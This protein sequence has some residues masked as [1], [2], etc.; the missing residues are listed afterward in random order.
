MVDFPIY[1]GPTYLSD[2]KGEK[3]GVTD[4]KHP[5]RPDMNAHDSHAHG[6]Y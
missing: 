1:L 4:P 6:G 2:R 5:Y 3:L